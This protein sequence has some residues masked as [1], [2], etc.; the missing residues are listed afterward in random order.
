MSN[1]YIATHLSAFKGT[2]FKA[3][4]KAYQRALYAKE[5][6]DNEGYQG[7]FKGHGV[8]TAASMTS[9]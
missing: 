7:K 4:A 9:L 2:H 1:H 3:N 8:N 5:F 6:L